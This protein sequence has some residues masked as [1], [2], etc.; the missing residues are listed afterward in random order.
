MMHSAPSPSSSYANA[1]AVGSATGAVNQL[2][3]G[4]VLSPSQLLVNTVAAESTR[5]TPR[6]PITFARM[7]EHFGDAIQ[8]DLAAYWE[9]V[10]PPLIAL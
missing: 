1:T 2:N 7:H 8:R 10:D 3:H 5:A 9:L 6:P 4:L